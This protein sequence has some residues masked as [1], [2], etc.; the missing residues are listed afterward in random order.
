MLTNIL[1][2]ILKKAERS[3]IF[4]DTHINK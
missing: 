2:E 4:S 1:T 3:E